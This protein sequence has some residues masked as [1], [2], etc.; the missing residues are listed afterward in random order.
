MF[1]KII[2]CSCCRKSHPAHTTWFLL[3]EHPT[4]NSFMHFSLAKQQLPASHTINVYHQKYLWCFSYGWVSKKLVCR[5]KQLVL[6]N[7]KWTKCF[8]CHLSIKRWKMGYDLSIIYLSKLYELSFIAK[9][10]ISAKAS[11]TLSSALPGQSQSSR[12]A[13]A[14]H[15]CVVCWTTPQL[16]HQ[17]R[18]PDQ[19]QSF[20]WPLITTQI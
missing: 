5:T 20:R 7:R 14:Q 2:H 4:A 13:E 6:I 8:V 12:T 3:S 1:P 16:F 15:S 9:Q 17:A 19:S 10:S 18:Q 11:V